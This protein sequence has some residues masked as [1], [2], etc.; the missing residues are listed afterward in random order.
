MDII[1][2]RKLLKEVFQMRNLLAF[3]DRHDWIYLALVAC[4]M[5]VVNFVEVSI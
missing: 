2:H 1:M 4:A 3:L 5:L